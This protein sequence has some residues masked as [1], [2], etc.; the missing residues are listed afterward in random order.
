MDIVHRRT[1][2]DGGKHHVLGR[3]VEGRVQHPD[4]MGKL[5]FQRLITNCKIDVVRSGREGLKLTRA[6]IS[7]SPGIIHPQPL[8]V[9]KG[10]REA[11]CGRE[12][13]KI[14]DDRYLFGRVQA[15]ESQELQ[16]GPEIEIG[17]PDLETIA[18]AETVAIAHESIRIAE[19][20]VELRIGFGGILVIV[21][22]IGCGAPGIGVII[23]EL[24]NG[25]PAYGFGI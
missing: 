9:R 2:I 16:P 1:G 19:Q 18:Q 3:R 10:I 22:V 25:M 11:H 8:P 20:A 17:L 15:V 23:V 6:R 14:G 21:R 12:V 4:G 13:D 5:R 7:R 24:D